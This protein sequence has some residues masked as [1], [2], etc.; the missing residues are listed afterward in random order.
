MIRELKPRRILEIG[1]G[2]TSALILDTNERY[3]DGGIEC[4]FVEPYPELLHLPFT[5]QR[6]A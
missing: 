6:G 4:T 2:H 5:L 1:S 3:F